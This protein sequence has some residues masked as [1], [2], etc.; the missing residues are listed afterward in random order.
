MNLNIMNE[1]PT[2]ATMNE[3]VMKKQELIDHLTQNKAK[4]DVIL[5]TA[6][7]GYWDTANTKMEQRKT[8]FYTQL[9]EFTED[10][11]REFKRISDKITNKEELPSHLSIRAINIDSALGLVYPEDHT[12][13]YE[14]AIRMMQSSVFKQVK[15]TV[16][17]YDAYVL[18]N[19][20][21]KKNFLATNS[22]Y[23]D[24]MRS[25]QGVC[26]PKGRTG[27]V[28]PSGM[29]GTYDVYELA[30]NAAVGNIMLSGCAASF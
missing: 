10:V 25:K 21:W 22:F 30:S 7:A 2:M 3:V 12:Q 16:D 18:N 1:A 15:L 14:R 9:N 29:A 6:I 11:E 20:E 24:T 19:W 26:G 23:V 5:A 8:K 28:G 17:E 27:S 4:H 13:D